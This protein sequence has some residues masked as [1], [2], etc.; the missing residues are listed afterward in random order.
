MVL[1]QF[2]AKGCVQGTLEAYQRGLN[3]LYEDLKDE[4]RITHD[5]LRNWREKLITEEY[6]ASTINSIM[7]AA[8][9]YLEFVGAREYQLI[10]KLKPEVSPQP[11]ISRKEY[12]RL[13]SAAR[14]LGRDRVYFLLKIFANTEITLPEIEKVTV[15]AVTAGEITVS[16]NRVIQVMHIPNC[17]CVE[18]LAYAKKEFRE[19]RFC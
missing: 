10:D 14:F 16:F 3:K 15:E 5:T 9:G 1:D 8:N 6:S 18:L 13:L 7:A 11:E 2:I 12:L 4:K 17:I 19:A